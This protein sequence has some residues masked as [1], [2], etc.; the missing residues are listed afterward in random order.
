MVKMERVS[1]TLTKVQ[2]AQLGVVAV[3]LGENRS[4]VVRMA[5]ANFLK[6]RRGGGAVA[7]QGNADDALAS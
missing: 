1:L 3:Q 4:A 2:V 7:V 5:V 6:T